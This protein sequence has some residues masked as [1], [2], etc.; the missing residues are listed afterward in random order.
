M[1]RS[2]VSI[3]DLDNDE[4]ES[5][6]RLADRFLDEMATP[7][8]PYRVRG[9]RVFARD[10]ILATLFYE[11]S[12]RTRLSFES[13]M[14]R[15]GGQVI[16]SAEASSSSAAKGETIA[17]TV[18]IIENYADLMVIRHP[19]EGAARVA[20]EYTDLPVINGGDGGHE[21]PT[22]TLC[23]LYT[24]RA[25]RRQKHKEE[26][27]LSFRDVNIEIRGDLK[28]GRTIHS[29]V[30]ALARFGAR[31]IPSPAPGCDLPAHVR[32][33]LARDYNCVLLSKLE[34]E[35]G[36][37]EDFPEFVYVTPEGPHQRTLWTGAEANVWFQLSA[38]Q[39]ESLREL[40]S[41]DF[42]YATRFQK[43]RH[44]P[45]E[46]GGE[47]P[48]IDT[49]LLK[50]PRYRQTRVMHP[51]P[52]VD[53]LSYEL[54]DDPRGVYFKQAAYG[55][56]VRMA[57]IAA[58][59]ELFPSLLASPKPLR[60][61]SYSSPYGIQC[62]NP[63]CVTLDDQEKRYLL[64]KFWI[65]DE[66]RLTLRCMYCD[67]ERESAV[68]SRASTKKYTFN[69]MEWREIYDRNE[70]DLV[71]FASEQDAINAGHSLRRT[72]KRSSAQGRGPAMAG[73]DV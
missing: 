15:L 58:L 14:L 13:A 22:Q 28:H 17:D 3:D 57:L 1:A 39:R 21:H 45:N 36:A 49:E 11:P 29:L 73:T 2:V 9:R 30:Y 71:V 10:F 42:F 72:K 27:D 32:Q 68:I 25:A 48:P 66:Q 5:I 26:G 40:H 60:Y 34:I 6:F 44:Q 62:I 4:I 51:L 18:R 53:E 19:S 33:R 69:L 37:S 12:T 23:D 8:K 59:L 16:S 61:R 63:R 43:E 47:Y 54:D 7:G 20:A 38:E 50:D 65:V 52:R 46:Q 56:P 41:I 67:F 55:V 64:P 31:I 24:I 70:L 35:G